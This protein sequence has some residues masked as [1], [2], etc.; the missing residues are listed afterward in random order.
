MARVEG[1]TALY[2]KAHRKVTVARVLASAA[3]LMDTVKL[4]AKV[5]SVPAPAVTSLRTTHAVAQLDTRV[6]AVPLETAAR[7]TAVAALLL[8]IVKLDARASSVHA[9]AAT[10]LRM[11]HAVARLGIP[12]LT[13]P[14]GVVARSTEVVAL[15]LTI[16]RLDARASSELALGTAKCLLMA[17][18]VVPMGIRVLAVPLELAARST[19]VAALLLTIARLDAKANSE[20]ALGTA[21]SHLMAHAAVLTAIRV[22]VVP[23]ET[24]VRNT[25]VAGLPLTIVLPDARA[26]LALALGVAKSHLTQ[27]VEAR[28]ATRAKE[29]LSE[30]AVLLPDIVAARRRFV[31]LVAR[32]LLVHARPAATRSQRT[33]IAEAPKDKL[34]REVRS[35]TAVPASVAAAV[36]LDTAPL[37]VR[38][39]LES[40][41]RRVPTQAAFPRTVHAEG[42]K[43]TVSLL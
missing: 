15:P 24:A 12:V 21:K 40:A 35:E 31:R 5:N 32:L 33:V 19:E 8:V 6:L 43:N 14:L 16:A 20:L 2:A 29:V 1:R 39:P 4:G 25:V 38:A 10:F 23:L 42:P 13:V 28:T 17:R 18:A 37:G 11:A 41:R 30:I 27:A 22:L 36:R 3:V 7:N 34:V 9:P 26:R